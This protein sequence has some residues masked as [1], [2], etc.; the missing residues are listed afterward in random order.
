M[1]E[2]KYGKM[3]IMAKAINR[4]GSAQPLAEEIQWNHGGYKFNGCDVVTIEVV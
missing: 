3:A 2:S 1:G 4:A